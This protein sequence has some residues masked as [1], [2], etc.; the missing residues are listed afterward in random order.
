[1]VGRVGVGR[2]RYHQPRRGPWRRTVALLSLAPNPPSCVWTLPRAST[3][4]TILTGLQTSALII[5]RPQ[6]VLLPCGGREA[7]SDHNKTLKCGCYSLPMLFSASFFLRPPL[8]GRRE[9]NDQNKNEK[10]AIDLAKH[11]EELYDQSIIEC[12]N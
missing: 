8:V 1:M 4:T 11:T 9:F 7:P 10:G 6:G 3:V 12:W 2:G 5:S